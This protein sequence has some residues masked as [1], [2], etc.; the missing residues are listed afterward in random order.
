MDKYVQERPQFDIVRKYLHH[1]V[2]AIIDCTPKAG[3]NQ[4]ERY[5]VKA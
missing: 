2:M 4:V 5:K 1:N 3:H